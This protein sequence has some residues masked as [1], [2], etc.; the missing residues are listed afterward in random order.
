[1]TWQEMADERVKKVIEG[2][3]TDSSWGAWETA[4]LTEFANQHPEHSINCRLDV[5]R[6][7]G[8]VY[9][10]KFAGERANLGNYEFP[11]VGVEVALDEK[12]L[13]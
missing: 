4:C 3:D 7:T 9:V 8:K 13:P 5:T 10:E 11:I 1:M 6:I 12:M 2:G